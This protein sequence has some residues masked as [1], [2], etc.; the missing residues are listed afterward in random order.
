VFLLVTQAQI[1]TRVI[2]LHGVQQNL[3]TPVMIKLA[4]VLRLH[5]KAVFAD[6]DATQVHGAVAMHGLTS[7][8]DAGRRAVCLEAVDFH[9]RGGMLVPARLCP[10][11]FAMASIAISLATE[12]FVAA[13][14]GVGVKINSGTWQYCGQ[15]ELIE[16]KRRQFAGDLI[17]IGISRSMA[18]AGFRSDRKLCGIVETFIEKRCRYRAARLPLQMRSNKS[19]CPSRRSMYVDC[20]RRGRVRSVGAWRLACSC[21]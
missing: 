11:R 1:K 5:E 19:R 4:L 7:G 16:M 21:P 20:A 12:E 15:C 2:A 8:S 13:L 3:E 9:F 14:F 17:G 6:E 10:K 18:E